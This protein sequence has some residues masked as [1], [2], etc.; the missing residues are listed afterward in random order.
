MYIPIEQLSMKDKKEEDEE[1]NLD[2]KLDNLTVD[3]QDETP[4]SYY[5][6]GE[7]YQR[8]FSPSS[9][10]Q[11]RWSFAK[12]FNPDNYTFELYNVQK[13]VNDTMTDDRST[14]SRDY[15]NAVN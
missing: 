15:I 12:D 6:Q 3:L 13:Y 10:G 7:Q 5:V 4:S 14:K 9:S 11:V 1:T 8:T 2:F